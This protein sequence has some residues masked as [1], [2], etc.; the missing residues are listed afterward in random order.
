LWRA[1]WTFGGSDDG[2]YDEP[3]MPGDG[4]FG[5]EADRRDPGPTS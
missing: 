5:G 3:D 2:Y 1:G 4:F